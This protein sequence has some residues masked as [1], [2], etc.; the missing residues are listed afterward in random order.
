MPESKATS[1]LDMIIII[2]I[3]QPLII[4]GSAPKRPIN[5][6]FEQVLIGSR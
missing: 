1:F 3:T 6:H 2:G 5:N 4:A